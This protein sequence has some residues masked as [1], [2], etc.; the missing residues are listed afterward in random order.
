MAELACEKVVSRYSLSI[1]NVS[2]P[3]TKCLRTRNNVNLRF[4]R[5]SRISVTPQ[6]VLSESSLLFGKVRHVF[7]PVT[8]RTSGNEGN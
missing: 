8:H 5:Y 7:F 6:C 3:V 4:R 2:Q 1:V